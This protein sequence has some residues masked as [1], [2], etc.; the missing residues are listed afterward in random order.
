L[1]Q[2][3]DVGAVTSA[4]KSA[5]FG[6]VL[7]M[8]YIKFGFFGPDSAVEVRTEHGDLKATVSEMPFIRFDAQVES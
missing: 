6:R 5:A 4:T 8:A 1:S 2:D 3:R 7:A